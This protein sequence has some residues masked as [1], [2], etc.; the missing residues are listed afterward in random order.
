MRN[1]IDLSFKWVF[2]GVSESLCV[3]TLCFVI[4]VYLRDL[5][6][7]FT[8]ENMPA[9]ISPYWPKFHVLYAVVQVSEVEEKLTLPTTREWWWWGDYCCWSHRR[10]ECAAAEGSVCSCP[11]LLKTSWRL[12]CWHTALSSSG[13]PSALCPLHLGNQTAEELS[14]CSLLCISEHAEV[15][16]VFTLRWMITNNAWQFTYLST[17][18]QKKSFN[19]CIDTIIW[20][21]TGRQF[22]LGPIWTAGWLTPFQ[23]HFAVYPGP[24][25]IF[26]RCTQ[27]TLHK[28]SHQVNLCQTLL[29]ISY[30]NSSSL[31]MFKTT[32]PQSLTHFIDPSPKKSIITFP[33]LF[34]IHSCPAYLLF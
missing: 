28:K 14:V 24:A 16:D 15:L 29:V 19:L 30:I 21:L 10:W 4:S 7:T 2:A 18:E 12:N 11:H 6:A 26:G 5:Y 9:A 33:L 8:S 17:Q 22:L 31:N 3:L 23:K 32:G 25:F 1:L 13:L 34:G 27:I 20:E